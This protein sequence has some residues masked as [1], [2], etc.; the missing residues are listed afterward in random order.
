MIDANGS[1]LL[2]CFK[3]EWLV[4]LLM[5]QVILLM[6]NLLGELELFLISW[7]HCMPLAPFVLL[8]FVLLPVAFFLFVFLD[9]FFLLAC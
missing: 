7:F 2:V 4:V 1:Y 5:F 6:D 3:A 9:G 8:S